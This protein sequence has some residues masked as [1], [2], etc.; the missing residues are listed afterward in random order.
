MSNTNNENKDDTIDRLIQENTFQNKIMQEA[1][2]FLTQIKGIEGLSFL[3]SIKALI[4]RCIELES[5]TTKLKED[6]KKLTKK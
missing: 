4:K 1:K 5:E 6:I 3:A 2:F